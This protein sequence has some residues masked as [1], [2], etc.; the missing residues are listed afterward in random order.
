MEDERS[1]NKAYS[2]LLPFSGV[3][4]EKWCGSVKIFSETGVHKFLY[5]GSEYCLAWYIYIVPL[6]KGKGDKYEC[7]VTRDAVVC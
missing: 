6:Y 5:G 2:S 4:E 3:F 1:F 7:L